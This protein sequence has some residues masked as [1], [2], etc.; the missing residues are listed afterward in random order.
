MVEREISKRDSKKSNRTRKSGQFSLEEAIERNYE[1]AD[2]EDESELFPC[3]GG[4]S[5][6][7]GIGS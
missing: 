7:T 4:P 5:F 1:E 2:S 6:F 3:G